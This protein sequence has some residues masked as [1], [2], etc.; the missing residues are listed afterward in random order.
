MN[1]LKKGD[2]SSV[3]G[4]HM[5]FKHKHTQYKPTLP[6]ATPGSHQLHWNQGAHLNDQF[7]TVIPG[8][9]K[10][11]IPELFGDV[12]ALSLIHFSVTPVVVMGVS[13]CIGHTWWTLFQISFFLSLWIFSSTLCEGHSGI[14][15]SLYVGHC[16]VTASVN[17]TS[18]LLEPP[19]MAGAD[20]WNPKTSKHIDVKECDPIHYYIP[21]SL[22]YC[23]WNSTPTCGPQVSM[24]L[25]LKSLAVLLVCSPFIPGP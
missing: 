5:L 10:K 23:P 22:V 16:W 4:L 9:Q 19:P 17:Q 13:G 21:L 18:S 8:L 6:S 15:A 24:D 1:N 2:N 25:Y 12:S 20:T 14:S 11:V 7:P 3:A